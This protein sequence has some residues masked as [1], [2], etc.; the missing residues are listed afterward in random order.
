MLS[1]HKKQ[2]HNTMNYC[3]PY[4]FGD[5]T[6]FWNGIPAKTENYNTPL[7]R[8][9]LNVLMALCGPNGK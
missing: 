8:R 2:I 5:S 9:S 7:S 3:V 1:V 6:S 4:L